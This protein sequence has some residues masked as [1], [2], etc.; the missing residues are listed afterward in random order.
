MTE[1][2][3]KVGSHEYL[4]AISCPVQLVSVDPEDDRLFEILAWVS[5]TLE[6]I[7]GESDPITVIAR[8]RVCRLKQEEPVED[9]CDKACPCKPK[10]ECGL[11]S[12]ENPWRSRASIPEAGTGIW[13]KLT[14]S[15]SET[16]YLV[17]VS[18][19]EPWISV[20]RYHPVTD[21][22]MFSSTPIP[23]SRIR[24]WRPVK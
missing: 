15:D 1:T 14:H 17:R 11:K 9:C 18:D 13:V 19:E 16:E 6:S 12:I 7:P 8:F 20:A 4:D 22:V 24:C 2:K 23:R 21:H 5:E 10:E 3:F